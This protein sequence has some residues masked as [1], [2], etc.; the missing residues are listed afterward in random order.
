MKLKIM[1]YHSIQSA[2]LNMKMKDI[3]SILVA[4]N[5]RFVYCLTK[6]L[7]TECRIYQR[8]PVI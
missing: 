5:D 3:R 2:V 1:D 4:E 8:N 6:I 7:Q